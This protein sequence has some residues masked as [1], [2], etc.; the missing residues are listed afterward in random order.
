MCSLQGGLTTHNSDESPPDD[1]TESQSG[2][3]IHNN[4]LEFVETF[5]KKMMH[6]E[7]PFFPQLNG[8]TNLSLDD[9]LDIPGAEVPERDVD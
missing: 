6:V 7:F 5:T 4:E 2:C 3:K 9:E 8:G 1:R